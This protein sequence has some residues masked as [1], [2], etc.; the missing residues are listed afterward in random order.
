MKGKTKSFL[1]I[2]AL[3]SVS[4]GTF[5]SC[6][7]YDSDVTADIKGQVGDLNGVVTGQIDDLKGIHKYL[8]RLSD[9]L[10]NYAGRYE[11]DSAAVH[12]AIRDLKRD[13]FVADSIAKKAEADSKELKDSV[14]TRNSRYMSMFSQMNSEISTINGKIGAYNTSL[15][16]IR[17]SL[18]TALGNYVNLNT[19][20]DSC[21]QMWPDDLAKVM[22][23]AQEALTLAQLDSTKIVNMETSVNHAL[24]S[25]RLAISLA[26]SNLEEA[27]RYADRADSIAYENLKMHV[28]TTAS[29]LKR[30]Y[31]AAD[32]VL[33]DS[34]EALQNK[35]DD[36]ISKYEVLN[37]KVA[38]LITNIIIQGTENPI[39][40]SI[41]LPLNVNS[42][43]LAAYYGETGSN[44]VMFPTN[45]PTNYVRA[46]E[47]DHF[48]PL[49]DESQVA[50][51]GEQL[52]S[53]AGTLYLTVNPTNVNFNNVRVSLVNSRDAKGGYADLLLNPSDKLLSFGAGR[54]LA[55]NGFYEAQATV[56]DV[57]AAKPNV[58]MGKL[59]GVV[60]DVLH[61][62]TD[63]KSSF[64]L[65][66][67]VATV[68]E[69]VN[70]ALPAYGVKATW[71]DTDKDGN[72]TTNSVY[73]EYKIA[74]TAI[75]ALSYNFYA[76]GVNVGH[77]PQIPTL[78]SKGLLFDHFTWT[79]ADT[80]TMD[81]ISVTLTIP[82]ASSVVI[83]GNGVTPPITLD[84]V[85]NEILGDTIITNVKV[86]DI[87]FDKVK[88]E[89]GEK[90]TTIFVDVPYTEFNNII[91]QMN[92]NVGGMLGQV[93]SIVD[94]VNDMVKRLDSQF[95]TRVNNWIKRLDNLLHDPNRLFQIC[96]FYQA[97]NGEF[98]QLNTVEKAPSLMKLG[99]KTEGAIVLYPTSY[100]AEIFA[101]A[102][103]KYVAVTKVMTNK[104][105]NKSARDFANSAE[106]MNK[107]IDGDTRAIAFKVNSPGIYEIAY[108]AVDYCGKITTRT[109]YVEVEK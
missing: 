35:V 91:R 9:S 108:S 21:I 44:I 7:D 10:Y 23:K 81:P 4:L 71:D 14:D 50:G 94:R 38:N 55:K 34:I 102:F 24:D 79:D 99:G 61:K 49:I 32:A 90:D 26:N 82:D 104:V 103:K 66:N 42:N 3:F 20:L 70:N 19:R 48:N 29:S 8:T 74:A 40:G 31:E 100:T 47:A 18:G 92:D 60:K 15:S 6:N 43:F 51:A 88:V 83:N 56:N 39:F 52:V 86:G 5:V 57:N 76:D 25:A 16:G 87:P 65:V 45:D 54:G 1:L 12:A 98:A 62:V 17:D 59:K 11:A 93:N 85:Y 68:Y 41:N 37:N 73:S 63:R 77:L 101:P 30:A 67:A 58:D 2:L 109:F 97:P 72:P 78:E 22:A 64:S 28:D 75:P 33:K 105:E 106:G 95:I 53:G 36:M 80:I 27:K 84:K 96:M 69:E 46:A 107:V 89:I 13:A